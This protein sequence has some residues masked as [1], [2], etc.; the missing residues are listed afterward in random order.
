MDA[1]LEEMRPTVGIQKQKD[2]RTKSLPDH[3]KTKITSSIKLN[4]KDLD[5]VSKTVL[6]YVCN[7]IKIY[8]DC[9]NKKHG[10]YCKGYIIMVF[11]YR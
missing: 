1:V 8:P 2:S 11:P 7:L 9:N 4:K 3:S 6:L 10:N 5:V